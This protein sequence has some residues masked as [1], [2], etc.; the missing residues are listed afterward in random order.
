MSATAFV[1]VAGLSLP[2]VA[3]DSAAKKITA[4][5]TTRPAVT[6]K[7]A[8]TP[9]P[10]V[11]SK[12]TA[13]QPSL[14][15][16][17]TTARQR[18]VAAE[19]ADTVVPRY[20]VDA[21]GELVPDL[22]AAAAIIFNPETNEVL[23]EEHSQDSRSIASITKVMTATVFLEN[24]PDTSQVVTVAQSDVFQASTTH[25]RLNDKVTVDDLLH[26]MLIASDNA[27]ARALARISPQGTSGFI[28][29]MNEKAAELGLEST[30]Y[31]DSSGLLSDN[32]SSAYDMAR[33]IAHASADERIS[34]IMRL[35]DYTV[36]TPK[37]SIS[38][39]TTD[40]LLAQEQMDVRAAKTGFIS[41]SGYCLATLLRLPES[42]QQVAVVVLGARSNAGRFLETQ[43]LFHWL[44]S[45][46]STF[47][48]T[49]TPAVT[50]QQ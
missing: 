25:L 10:T 34:S 43:N 46:T 48:A 11:T 22:H 37:R 33:L 18:A 4:A 14:V 47:F 27:A 50:Q 7:P 49:E 13:P 6:P 44:S 29:R 9:R 31:A 23:W 38:F 42:G 21:A 3:A 39:H 16:K 24:D 5:T 28:V 26:L 36:R 19:P 30:H 8:V 15:K 20:K 1:V 41:K 40:R 35:S 45:K 2:A 32:V 12:P 17:A